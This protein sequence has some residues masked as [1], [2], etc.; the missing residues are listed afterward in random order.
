MPLSYDAPE[1]IF[2]LSTERTTY[3]MRVDEHGYL[4]HL[5]YGA[6]TSANTS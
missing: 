6:R 2:T 4:L 1:R 3:Q 5:D